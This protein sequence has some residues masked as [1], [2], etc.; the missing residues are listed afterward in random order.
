MDVTIRLLR[1]K[2]KEYNHLYFRDALEM[3]KFRLID[4]FQDVGM[5]KCKRDKET[6]KLYDATIFI[7]YNVDFDEE[8]FR[9]VLVHEMIHYYV[10][11]TIE[12]IGGSFQHCGLFWI[13]KTVLNKKYKLGIQSTYPHIKYLPDKKRKTG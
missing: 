7:A 5:F 13:A 11:S 8:S 4:G 10:Y 1:D 3:P 12:P 2:F 9:S 6:H